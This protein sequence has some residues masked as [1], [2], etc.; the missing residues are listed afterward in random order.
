ML[1]L[2]KQS[3]Q[4]LIKCQII[5]GHALLLPQRQLRADWER[6]ILK[7]LH[8]HGHTVIVKPKNTESKTD[9]VK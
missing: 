8:L 1:K 7:S 5:H 3:E 9:T 2:P 6:S 4:L